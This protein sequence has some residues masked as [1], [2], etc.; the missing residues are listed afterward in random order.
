MRSEHLQ[1]LEAS[2]LLLFLFSGGV[3]KRGCDESC[4]DL[5]AIRNFL[6]S[7]VLL[8]GRMKCPR[9][10]DELRYFINLWNGFRNV[11]PAPSRQQV[12]FRDVLP[13]DW[14]GQVA[15]QFFDVLINRRIL[16]GV[17]QAAQ[18]LSLLQTPIASFKVS[19]HLVGQKQAFGL[20]TI[21]TIAVGQVAERHRND[22]SRPGSK[23]GQELNPVRGFHA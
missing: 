8:L 17:K 20:V 4:G 13:H 12:K 10:L 2:P 21:L 5:G 1:A 9:L 15:Q 6:R 7:V 14:H 11:E 16:S 3:V 18:V 22:D 23:T 19:G